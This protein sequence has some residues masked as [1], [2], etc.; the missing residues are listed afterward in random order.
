MHTMCCTSDNTIPAFRRDA[1]V[2][3]HT[4]E[5]F[6]R[7]IELSVHDNVLLVHHLDSS[8]VLLLDV[9]ARSNGPIAGPLPLAIALEDQVDYCTLLALH[10]LL[11]NVQRLSFTVSFLVSFLLAHMLT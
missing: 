2:L 7:S 11:Q 5:I 1:V 4:Y 6:S 9:R 10:P 3:Q 8:T